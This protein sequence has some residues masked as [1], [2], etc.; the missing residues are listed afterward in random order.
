MVEG[1]LKNTKEATITL[2]P[3]T[4]K[5]KAEVKAKPVPAV[6]VAP[7]AKASRKKSSK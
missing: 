2:P 4:A 7:A 3:A 1:Y 6:K 5:V